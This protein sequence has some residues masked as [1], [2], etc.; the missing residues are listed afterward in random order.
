MEKTCFLE[1]ER[2]REGARGR[3]RQSTSPPILSLVR[4]GFVLV[5]A[6]LD[7]RRRELSIGVLDSSS[8]FVLGYIS[9]VFGMSGAF[10]FCGFRFRWR[11]S[12][13][14]GCGG[15]DGRIGGLMKVW[16]SFLVAVLAVVLRNF[17][18]GFDCG[19]GF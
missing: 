6:F 17:R 9:L 3:E 1:R 11:L 8:G 15:I 12:G 2:G 14:G 18:F 19:V 4:A 16:M 5:D 13:S 7:S 10:L